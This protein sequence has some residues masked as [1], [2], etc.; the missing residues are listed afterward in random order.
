M[1]G[2]GGYGD[3]GGYGGGEHSSWSNVLSALS[4]DSAP[5]ARLVAPRGAQHLPQLA[6]KLRIL[7]AQPPGTAEAG[8]VTV[9]A[10]WAAGWG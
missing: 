3:R 4:E 6:P 7:R 10:A 1:G 5:S 2:G 9:E 8:V